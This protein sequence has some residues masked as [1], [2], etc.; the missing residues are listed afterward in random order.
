M[1]PLFSVV[2]PTY[3]RAQKVTRAVESVLAQT[4]NDYEIWVIDD[5]TDNT[6]EVLK[7][8]GG[9]LNYV[10]GPGPGAGAAAT[11]NLGINSA[12]GTY[13]AFLDSDDW[14][15][16]NKLERV[17][18][19]LKARPEVGLFY[20][21]M[22][23]VDISGA[24]IRTPNIREVGNN[25]YYALLEGNFV[26][27]STAVVK[28]EALEQVGGFDTQLSGC[29]DWELWIRVA[30]RY[31]VALIP[32]PLVAYEYLSKDSLSGRYKLWLKAHDEVLAKS[33]VADPGLELQVKHLIEAG[34]AYTKGKICIQL[35]DDTLA[36]QYFVQAV[37]LN[38]RN[39]R[40]LIY[41]TILRF[42]G[43]RRALPGRAKQ[44]LLL[45]EKYN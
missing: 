45:P 20:S 36:L 1:N 30:R 19:M 26:F 32:E 34:L 5:G 27:N 35:G 2:I 25:A 22:D 43:L 10:R 41:V 15:F 29:E 42:P 37:R 12:R 23:L 13:I 17:V 24:R 33:F 3:N 18:A 8:F 28:R 7:L 21:N 11:R 4:C 44:F 6:E 38:S 14:W 31:P 9:R 39:W 40:A 16:P